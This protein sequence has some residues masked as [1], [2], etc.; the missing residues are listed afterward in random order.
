[1]PKG[2]DP[3]ISARIR[4]LAAG[5]HGTVDHGALAGAGISQEAISARVE[6]GV[7]ARSGVRGL[8]VVPD[9]RDGWTHL[10]TVLARTSLLAASH[11]TA[12][13]A[14]GW[15]GFDRPYRGWLTDPDLVTP[16]TTRPG[17]EAHRRRDVRPRDFRPVAGIR[18]TDPLTTLRMLEEKDH[19]TADRLEL[20]VECALRRRDVSDAA[21]WDGPGPLLGEV[22]RRRGRGTPPTGSLLETVALQRVLRPHGLREVAR[23]VEVYD[24]GTCLGRPD[25]LLEGWTFLE[26]D[27]GQHD[28]DFERAA[29]RARD[30]RLEALG[31]PVARVDRGQIHD[32]GVLASRLHDL[33]RRGR[34]A[35]PDGPPPLRGNRL[36]LPQATASSS[37]VA[38]ASQS[39]A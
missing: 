29:D 20:A 13:A 3:G 32:A 12:A 25:F 5:R 26:V 11:R 7:L 28:D 27:G 17:F 35:H 1:M 21:L 39:S 15:D 14:Y 36:W 18:V 30:L 22:L 16:W 8:Y 37:P 31:L 6:R 38:N 19:V 4:A 23:Q 24:R 10:V 9:L 33:V 2:F 34:A